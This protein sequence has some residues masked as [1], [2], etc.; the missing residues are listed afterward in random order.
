MGHLINYEF[1]IGTDMYRAILLNH[2]HN[3]CCPFRELYMDDNT[4]LL[5]VVQLFF[6]FSSE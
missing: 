6:I 4:I 1:E 2:R 3:G 5:Q